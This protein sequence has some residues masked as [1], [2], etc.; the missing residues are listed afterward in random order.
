MTKEDLVV[1]NEALN[2]RIKALEEGLKLHEVLVDEA[3]T[4]TSDAERKIAELEGL[5]KQAGADGQDMFGSESDW[6]V[7]QGSGDKH[8]RAEAI[9]LTGSNSPGVM[10]RYITVN[11]DV[12]MV[13]LYANAKAIKSAEGVCVL[14]YMG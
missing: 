4:K 6:M 5:L 1:E 13:Q 14:K 2:T 8:G 7:V 11:S 12:A 9:S 3:T 10:L